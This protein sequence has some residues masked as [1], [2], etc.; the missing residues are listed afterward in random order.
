MQRDSVIRPRAQGLKPRAWPAIEIQLPV[1]ADPTLAELLFARLDDFQPTAIQEGH[2]STLRAFFSTSGVRDAA[3]DALVGAF[4]NRGVSGRPLDVDDQDWA[5]RSQAEL[6]AVQVG[7]IVIAPPW[8]V[9]EGGVGVVIEPSMGFGTGHHAST[10]LCL[11]ALQRLELHGRQLL[12][13]GT[14]S[15]VLA[16]AAVLLGTERVTA[17]DLDPDALQSA[18]ENAARNGVEPGISF[19]Q[20]DFRNACLDPADIVLA[21][22]TGAILSRTFDR[23]VELA[24]PTGCLIL[25]GFTHEELIARPDGPIATSSRLQ[26]VAQLDEDGWRCF[27]LKKR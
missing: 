2:G 15:G 26:I 16:I 7:R 5:A 25:S 8:D 18:R 24:T 23:L 9:P 13:I 22:L 10:R 21:N 19:Q 17:I 14:G 3:L 12:D 20:V 1:N 27:V 4:A 6:R 11:D